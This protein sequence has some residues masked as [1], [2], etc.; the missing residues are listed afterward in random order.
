MVRR[1]RTGTR[2][3]DGLRSLPDKGGEGASPHGVPKRRLA[4]YM[5][6]ATREARPAVG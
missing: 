3:Q 5:R 4:S 1:S 2:Q 6:F